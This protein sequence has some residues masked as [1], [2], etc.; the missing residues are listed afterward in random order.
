VTTVPAYDIVVGTGGLGTGM[1][2]S[3]EGDHTLGREES[4]P[5]RLLDQRDSC[6]LHIVCHYVQRLLG[7]GFPVVPIG[8]VGRDGPGRSVLEEMRTTGLDTSLVGLSTR[9]TLFSVCFLYPSGGGGN[10]STV[11]SASAEVRAEDVRRA[12]PQFERNRGRGIAM[13]LPE[14]PLPAR[15][16]LLQLARE[17]DFFRVAALVPSEVDDARQLGLLQNVDLLAVNIDEAAALAQVTVDT[18]G[19]EVVD[20]VVR[21]L[22]AITE[23]ASVIVTFGGEGSWAW[24]GTSLTHAS[25]LDVVPISTAGAGDAHLAGVVVATALGAGLADANEVGAVVA[26]LKV[27]SRHTINPDIDL[28][29]V[30]EAGRTHGRPIPSLERLAE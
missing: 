25:A 26:G 13:A 27:G 5:A 9:P 15:L 18:A 3:L 2:L 24:D 17:H 21:Q 8:K 12:L 20:E 1:F 7:P 22:S 16:A 29:S 6:K 14:V 28:A 23:G 11:D 4:R 30:L 10:L 19:V